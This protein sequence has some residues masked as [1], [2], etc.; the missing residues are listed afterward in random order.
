M[1]NKNE[2][3]QIREMLGFSGLSEE[4]RRTRA[5]ALFP[6]QQKGFESPSKAKK[7]LGKVTFDKF[8]ASF[9]S[10]KD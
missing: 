6:T 9:R 7:P 1:P 4:D 2:L 5:A 3:D 8:A 10:P